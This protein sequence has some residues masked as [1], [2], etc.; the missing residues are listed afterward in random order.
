MR[1]NIKFAIKEGAIMNSKNQSDRLQIP[2]YQIGLIGATGGL[3][4]G[5]LKLIDCNFYVECASSN[6]AIAG[7]LT[8]GAYLVLGTI[9][10]IFLSDHELPASI[11]VLK[12]TF[13]LRRFFAFVLDDK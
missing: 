2:W 9:T 1:S 6:E 8:Y 3:C 11:V 5:I 12:I 13:R 10:A 7:F 4:L